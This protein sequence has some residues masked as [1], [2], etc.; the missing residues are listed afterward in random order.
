MAR[1]KVILQLYPMFPADDR[2]D[3]EAKRP[4][5]RDDEMYQHILHEWLEVV[6]AADEMGVWGV[7]TIEH[8]FHSE[9]YE[10]GPNP[11]ILNA[12]WA[13]H[14]KNARVGALGYVMATQDPIRVAEECA[15]L[16]H[17]T[18]GKFFCGVARGYQSRWTN[19]L[20]QATDSVAAVARYM[21]QEEDIRNRAI[22][23][24]RTEML[25]KCWTED[26]LVLDGDFYQAPYPLEEGI[27]YPA[28]ESAK[29]AG[30]EGE[31]DDEGR[32]RRVS[33]VPKP[34][35]DPYP[36][37]FQAVSA[38][39]ESIQFAA[40]HGFRPTYFTKIEKMEEFSHLYVEEA[41]KAG[42]EFELG[43]RQNMCRWIHV[44]DSEKEYDEKLEAYD[45]DIYQNF[46]VPFFPQFPDDT[47]SIDWVE[48]IKQSGIFHGGTVDRLTQDFHD[49]Y[50]K[51]PAEFITLIW[52]YAQIPKDEMLYELEVFM[53]QV[54]PELEA[55]AGNGAAVPVGG[56]A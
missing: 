48:N 18:Q 12:W 6:K 26:S 1:P 35:Q 20:G 42:F 32:V 17:I 15:I 54:I 22:F 9:G 8:H 24:E 55:P 16:D 53:N 41:A 4:M 27:A 21:G 36:P 40:K 44:A 28:W 29:N 45:R 3:R 46:Y 33:V 38:S 43:E 47:S 50:D 52:H 13:S 10:V 19:V 51:V 39:P 25:L 56:V 5:G 37:M 23:E 11:G 49:A 7:S 31:I 30:T 2:A 14:L 34:Y